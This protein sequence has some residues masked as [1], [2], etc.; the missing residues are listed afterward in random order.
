MTKWTEVASELNYAVKNYQGLTKMI[1]Q[2]SN[3][4]HAYGIDPEFEELIHGKYGKTGKQKLQGLEQLKGV[5]ARRIERILKDFPIWTDWLANV[6]G[7][8]PAIGGQLI[9]LYY[10]KSIPIC[11]KCGADL[12]G[13][14]KCPVCHAEAAGQGVLKYRIELRDFPH[15]SGWWHFMG[16][17]VVN[18]KMP[19]R[20]KMDD[21]DEANPNNWS[22]PGRVLGHHIKESFNKMPSSHKYK[23][24]AEKRK[25]YRLGTHPDATKGHRHNMAWN[26]AVK[27]FLS[28]FWQ[29]AR[30][31][32]GLPLTDP[33]CVK[34][35]GHDTG[36]IIPP[37]YFGDD[38]EREAA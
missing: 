26:E 13:D 1:V 37:Y 7:I 28:H 30:T 5:A 34:F 27:L 6:P 20:R 21:D 24:Y 4:A 8:G 11:Q 31:L 38:P 19:K 10:F 23:A 33:W 9:A 16:R 2:I 3:R 14:F 12:D 15:I 25:Q 32:D 22:A 18:G 36:S 29:V 17:H 35:G